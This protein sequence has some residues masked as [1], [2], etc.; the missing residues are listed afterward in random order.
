MTP[1]ITDIASPDRVRLTHAATRLAPQ[2]SSIARWAGNVS[3]FRAKPVLGDIPAALHRGVQRFCA[4]G[5]ANHT[6]I[7]VACRAVARVKLGP[8]SPDGLRRGSLHSA[9]ASEGYVWV[10]EP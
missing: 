7:G 9:H 10:A 5:V 3:V 1:I 8:P 2:A 6:P 4:N